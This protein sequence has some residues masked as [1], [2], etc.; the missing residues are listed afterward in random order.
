MECSR[1]GVS[2]VS[3][4]LQESSDR[5]KMMALILLR[6]HSV[7]AGIVFI[8]FWDTITISEFQKLLSNGHIQ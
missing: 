5:A 1:T 7:S 3:S 2:G 4:R 6:D 8:Y